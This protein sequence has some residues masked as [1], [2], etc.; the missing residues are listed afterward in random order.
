MNKDLLL[1]AF[2]EDFNNLGDVTGEAIFSEETDTF[3]LV[4]KQSGVLCGIKEFQT[5]FSNIDDEIDIRI[6]FQDGDPISRGDEIAVLKGKVASI[7]KA[8]RTA[9]NL[10]SHLSGIAT[11]TAQFVK[12]AAG[13]AIILDTRKTLP[14]W[15]DLQKYAVRCGGGNN[16]RL[17]LY[18]MVMIKDNHIDAAGGITKAVEKIRKKWQDKF[19]IEVE[20][21]NLDEVREALDCKIDRIMLDNMDCETMKKAVGLIAGRCEI[22]ASGNMTLD[23]IPQVADTGV[24]FISVGEL[25]HSVTAFDFSLKKFEKKFEKS[26]L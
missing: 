26:Y 11:K 22:E 6:N 7:L 16:H 18:D 13:K 2:Q 14:G 25:T 4:A 1:S 5:V 15:R 21:R 12:A 10:I 3:V 20:T 17:G 9:L 19:R 24:D 8:E 23:R